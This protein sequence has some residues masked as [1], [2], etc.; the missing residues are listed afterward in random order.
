[1]EK[2]EAHYFEKAASGLQKKETN[3]HLYA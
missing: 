1:M 3:T 2:V